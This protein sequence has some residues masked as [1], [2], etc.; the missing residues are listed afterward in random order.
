M[1]MELLSVVMCLKEYCIILLGA[2]I[3]VYT[4]HCNLTYHNLN[5]QQVLRWCCF[6]EDFIPKL[7]YIPGSQNML[8]CAFLCLPRM[9][10]PTNCPCSMNNTDEPSENL[11]VIA[12]LFSNLLQ[13]LG[14]MKRGRAW[15]QDTQKLTSQYQRMRKYLIASSIPLVRQY[16]RIS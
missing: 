10:K 12:F 7:Y 6:L 4:D 3:D 9:E 14:T 13:Q 8:V 16:R 5:P 2:K 15:L 1:E 11:T